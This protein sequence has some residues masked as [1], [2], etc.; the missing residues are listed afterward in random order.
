MKKSK[1]MSYRVTSLLMALMFIIGTA[2]FSFAAEPVS[3]SEANVA[4]WPTIE[5]ELYWGQKL[6]DGFTV[7]GGVVTV[8][9]T[10]DGEVIP[11]RFV[12]TDSE[13]VPITTSEFADLKFIP[14]NEQDYVGFEIENTTNVVFK[15]NLVTPVLVDENDVPV[16]SSVAS[17]NARITTSTLTGGAVKNPYTGEVLSAVWAW[18]NRR[19]K[20]AESGYFT[21]VCSPGLGYDTIYMDVYVSIAGDAPATKVEIE[22]SFDEKITYDPTLTW[23]MLTLTGGKA[24][25]SETGA[26]IEGTFAVSDEYKD[27]AITVGERTLPVIFTPADSSQGIG[28]VCQVP[29]TVNKAKMKF[30]DENG[31]EIVPEITVPYGTKFND[32]PKLLESYVSGPD[33]IRVSVG[34]LEKETC[35]EGTFTCRV[36]APNDSENYET[37]EL[38]FKI[39]IEKKKINPTLKSQTGSMY[40]EDNTAE[41]HPTG[42]FTLEYTIDGVE[43]TPITGIKYNTP[44]DWNPTKSGKYEYKII[45]NEAEENEYFIIDDFT[46][47]NPVKLSWAFSAT[48]TLDGEY[49]YGTEVKL[50]APATDPAKADK[51]YYGFVKWVD[52]NGNTGLSEEELENSEITFTMPDGAVDLDATYKFDF[53]LLIQYWFNR[54]VTFFDSFFTSIGTL[55]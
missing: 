25:V 1:K 5:G 34:D 41:Y 38:T 50:E 52:N 27:R 2:P 46:T 55:F 45:Y 26:E 16:A 40:I 32:V 20:V 36:L 35:T 28:C 33:V 18:N 13:Y 8:D 49:S 24:V 30:V 22:P 17:V 47:S 53:C 9:G 23:G 37:T 48:G 15:V 31:N 6:S 51:P 4:V 10:A 29:V 43:Q 7:S 3:L 19:D 39:V 44:F 42:T 21:A 14:D 12:F 54:I 11:G